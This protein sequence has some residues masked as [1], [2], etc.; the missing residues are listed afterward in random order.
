MEKDIIALKVRRGTSEES[1]LGG[2]AVVATVEVNCT[3]GIT[4]IKVKNVW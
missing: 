1:L 2:N 3:P 4:V